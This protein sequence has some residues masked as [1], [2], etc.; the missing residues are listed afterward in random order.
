MKE[1]LYEELLQSVSDWIWAVD[2][3]GIYTYC[4]KNVYDFLGYHAEEVVGKTP[5]DFMSEIEAQR[6]GNVFFEHISKKEKILQLENI[7]IHKNGQEVIVETTGIPIFDD[8]NY[9]VGYQ[10]FD[11]DITKQ[12]ELS[13]NIQKQ[14]NAFEILFEQSPDGVL[15]IQD[16]YF[17]QCN[18]EIVKMLGYNSK[19]ELL[20]VHPSKLSPEFQPDGKDS[21]TK[22]EEMMSLAIKN[23]GHNFEWIHKRANGDNFWTEIV[24]TPIS[25]ADR[26]IIHVSWRDISEQKEAEETI[27]EKQAILIQQARHA[28]MGEMIANIAHQWRQ[29]L[30]ALGLIMQK[31]QLFENHG[32]LDTKKLNSS[33]NKSMSLINNMS[34]TIDDF[35]GF[36]NPR[37]IKED[38]LIT[39]SISNA[40]NILEATLKNSNI[41]FKLNIK[42]SDLSL[43]GY[44]NEFSQVILNLLNNSKD[45]LIEKQIKHASIHVNVQK[46]NDR[47]VIE[48]IDNG[49]GIE[50][51]IKDEIFNPYFT[52]KEEGKGDGIGLYMSRIIVEDHMNGKLSYKNTSNGVCFRIT[53]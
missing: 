23:G 21:Y 1:I 17:V 35:R 6:I 37:K 25:F 24:L 11:R 5:F 2:S 50:S 40:Y 26:D 20:N 31:I 33:I 9:L 32:V 42:D 52:S 48:V 8:D 3:N 41:S 49:G 28:S 22:A 47:I 39:D 44:K 53:I 14:N 34:T 27:K 13:K 46:K 29:P 10:G 51:N 4:S 12:K 30:N 16:N 43:H 7:H 19:E 36:F 38:F 18:Q 45:V 15:I